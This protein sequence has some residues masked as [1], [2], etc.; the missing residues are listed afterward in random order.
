MA[1]G[2]AARFGLDEICGVAVDVE[3]YVASVEPDNGVQLRGCVVHEHMCI[4]DGVG[5]GQSLIGADFI[6]CGEHCGVNSARDVEKSAVNA[7]HARD[8]VFIK[9]RYGRGVGRV[10]QLGTIRRREPF[11][12]RVLGERGNGVLEALQGFAD[13]VG[14][15]DVDVIARVVPFYGKYAVI[16]ARGVGDDGVILPERVEEVGG[17]VGGEELDS[18]VI[19]IEREG[20]RQGCMGPKTRV[21]DH[22]ITDM[23]LEVAEK[24][25]VGDDDG[26]LES[27][28]PLSDINV[29][30]DARVGD[31]EEGVLN[32]HLVWDFF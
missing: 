16:A 26:F 25:L 31:G 22:R 23:G 3:A 1:R 28:H 5:G 19:Y 8:V 7:L 2:A 10:L 13:G 12:G 4:L 21:V 20:G 14:N 15:G 30:I 6:E 11:V 17:V 9:F 18:E 29:D 27:V 32:N 24:A